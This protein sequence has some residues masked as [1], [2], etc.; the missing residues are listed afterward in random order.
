MS[1][2]ILGVLIGGM[3]ALAGAVAGALINE[4]FQRRRDAITHARQL[5]E[6]K[7]ARLVAQYEDL[8]LAAEQFW[9][10]VTTFAYLVER[11][12]TEPDSEKDSWETQEY[13]H[14]KQAEGAF[15]KASTL[16]LL[17][18]DQVT[19]IEHCNAMDSVY[20]TYLSSCF[21]P[22]SLLRARSSHAPV[23][24]AVS[25]AVITTKKTLFMSQ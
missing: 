1:G 2:Q 16:L 24:Q 18:T 4:I 17:E 7:R 12:R 11:Y 19:I 5:A 21:N 23:D 8:M 9:N 6:N 25:N 13:R 14:A 22:A 3:I 10:A 15:L 20:V